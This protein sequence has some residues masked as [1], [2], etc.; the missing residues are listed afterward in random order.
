[1]ALTVAA[2]VMGGVDRGDVVAA[3]GGIISLEVSR[4]HQPS[5]GVKGIEN[6][7]LPWCSYVVKMVAPLHRKPGCL[8]E[9]RD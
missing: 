1:M 7:G 6:E 8:S 4:V 5:R 2:T 3:V 9:K